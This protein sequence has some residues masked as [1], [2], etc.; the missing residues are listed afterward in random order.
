MKTLRAISIAIAATVLLALTV[1]VPALA[2]SQYGGANYHWVFAIDYAQANMQGSGTNNFNWNTGP[3]GPGSCQTYPNGSSANPYFVFGP[4]ATPFPLY[5]QDTPNSEVVSPSTTFQTGSSCGFSSST[6]HSHITFYVK[7]GT[8]GLQEALYNNLKSPGP[9][10]VILDAAWKAY[11][12]ALPGSQTP[13]AEIAAIPAAFGTTNLILVDITAAPMTYYSWSGAA[14]TQVSLP[15]TPG[16]LSVS[17]TVTTAAPG[18]VRTIIGAITTSNASFSDGS[19]SLVG[20]RGAATIPS[21]TTA[22]AGYVYGTQ[23]KLIV[24]G[25]LNGS[26]WT[27]GNYGQLDISA[28]QGLSTNPPGSYI[29]PLWADAGA[30][31]PSV[32]CASC[33]MLGLT[34]TTATTFNSL[35]FTAAK[36]GYFVDASNV[37]N[38][39]GWIAA[40]SASSAC[41]TT[42]LLKVSTAGGAGYIHVCSN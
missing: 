22:S 23:G 34:N 24:A 18:T 11:I 35:F 7:S 21:G 14:Y 27:F 29:A 1:A 26:Q 30:T 33:N 16:T 40:S 9:L 8:G 19:S 10:V 4:A 5:L 42:Y 2:Q 37:T 6:S 38:S 41:T 32:T 3:T 31:G 25:T 13:A 15:Y 20:V 17:N 28:A 39:G 36:A 12:A